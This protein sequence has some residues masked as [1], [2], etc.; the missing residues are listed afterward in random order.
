MWLWW[1]AAPRADAAACSDAL[2]DAP[3]CSAACAPAP[4][5]LQGKVILAAAEKGET[6]RFV[7]N[8]IWLCHYPRLVA[9]LCLQLFY[10]G[11]QFAGPLFLNQIVKFITKPKE[12]QTVCSLKGGVEKTVSCLCVEG[13]SARR[14]GQRQG[15]QGSK[16][17]SR[18]DVSFWRSWACASAYHGLTSPALPR[19]LWQDSDLNKCYVFAAMMF[20]APVVGTLAAGQANRL[21]VGTQI[22]VRAELTASIYRKALRLR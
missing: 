15:P 7:L 14:G 9:A 18:H 11:I 12:L 5:L 16:S 20:V 3:A 1:H 2:A 6:S 21:S 22:M 8:S 10:S 13:G 17:P 4:C 19:S